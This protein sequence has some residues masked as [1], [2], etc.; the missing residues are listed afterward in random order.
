MTYRSVSPFNGHVL[1]TFDDMSDSQVA[2]AVA[3]AGSRF[4]EWRGISFTAR[5]RIVAWRCGNGMRPRPVRGSEWLTS[6]VRR[7]ARTATHSARART[8]WNRPGTM[9]DRV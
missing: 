2:H 9:P 3:T 1:A 5:A 7:Q 8:F 4:D 6:S